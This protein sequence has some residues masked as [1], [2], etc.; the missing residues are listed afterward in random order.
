MH[1]IKKSDPEYDDLIK[2]TEVVPKCFTKTENGT[3]VI[4]S[5]EEL[6][7]V[8]ENM[9]H[10]L[11][12]QGSTLDQ[13]RNLRQLI[14]EATL[15]LREVGED[16]ESELKDNLKELRKEYMKVRYRDQ[17]IYTSTVKVW[18]ESFQN[19]LDFKECKDSKLR[20]DV[21]IP[22]EKT[23]ERPITFADITK[24]KTVKKNLKLFELQETP[25]ATSKC[26]YISFF[27]HMLKFLITDV[28]SPEATEGE[29]VQA[30]LT[31]NY[32]I[33]TIQHQIETSTSSQRKKIGEDMIKTK[34]R[35]K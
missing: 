8:K 20:V 17:R 1:K 35:A 34:E 4:L 15:Q 18:K 2:N 6:S 26:K 32:K 12:Q 7:E 14:V 24:A 30:L 23:V 29:Y 9:P 22:Y 28:G 21:F 31:K 3:V 13:L 5:E 25:N 11:E 10:E 19:H 27:E 16:P 33:K